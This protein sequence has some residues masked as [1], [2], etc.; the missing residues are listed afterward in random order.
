MKNIFLLLFLVQSVWSQTPLSIHQIEYN[1]H[2][3]I[4]KQASLFKSSQRIIPLNV[5]KP[6]GPTKTVFGYLPDW[7]Y[8]NAREHLQYNLLSHI[9][10]FDF[11]VASNGNISTP[12]YWPWTDVINKAHENGVKVIMTAVNFSAE[13]IHSILTNNSI[14][15]NFFNKVKTTL[16]TWDLQGVNIDFESLYEAD[17]GIVLN[18]FMNELST[19]IHSEISDSEV[20]FAGPAVNWGGWDLKG[21]SE[22]CDYIFIMAYSFAGS[23]SS[24]TGAN[25]PLEGGSI[26][27]TNTIDVQ[28]KD[29]LNSQPERLILGVPYY[30]NRW[31]T[32]S[33]LPFSK[34]L[35]F[36]NSPRYKTAEE[37]SINHDKFWDN[38][39]Q[40]PWYR[41]TEDSKNYQVWFDD[42]K[43]IGLKYDLADERS[44]KGIGMWAL[45]YDGDRDE[46]WDLLYDRYG[47]PTGIQ[48]P[49]NLPQKARIGQ[50][51]PN[52]FS[53]ST[54]ISY[55]VSQESRI[56]LR[57]IKPS[58]GIV[59]QKQITKQVQGEHLFDLY[60][61]NL[62]VGIYFYQIQICDL[63]SGEVYQ[64]T[65]KMQII[66]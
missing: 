22:A 7:E 27:I 35:D 36:I 26:N 39:S 32:E 53:F 37:E 10:A 18:N 50:N 48:T 59:F 12:S 46:L 14:K 21:L 28:Y 40:S 47:S 17:R 23:W 41:Y 24:S 65:Y 9:A 16:Q 11:A 1:Q 58:G 38:T 63:L 45:G 31:Q 51:Y 6:T 2:K 13:E 34:T 44:L 61:E 57:I 60:F 56:M 8:I 52:P 43:S 20:S 33:L 29:V 64:K 66:R 15:I 49:V 42:K 62:P 4:P 55:Y 5:T 30:G 19:F 3:D 25:A 54:S